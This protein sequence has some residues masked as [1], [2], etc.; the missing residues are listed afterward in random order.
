MDLQCIYQTRHYIHICLARGYKASKINMEI[1]T[2]YMLVK[3]IYEV[4]TGLGD[5]IN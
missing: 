5:S 1:S 4:T 2:N 3:R